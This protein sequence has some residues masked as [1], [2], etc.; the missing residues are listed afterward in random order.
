MGGRDSVHEQIVAWLEFKCSSYQDADFLDVANWRIIVK[1]L[2]EEWRGAGVT[3]DRV[4][5]SPGNIAFFEQ[6]LG[7]IRRRRL[8][9]LL[10]PELPVTN[11]ALEVLISITD[12][13]TWLATL[14]ME[15]AMN[16]RDCT[17]IE[18]ASDHIDKVWQE[19]TNC[20]EPSPI[21][22]D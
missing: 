3:D 12:L 16:L 10:A 21:T 1:N 2:V 6:R 7:L 15:A 13:R 14:Q 20:R 17:P 18:R 9:T 22:L 11:A 4:P 5:Y 8:K 19:L